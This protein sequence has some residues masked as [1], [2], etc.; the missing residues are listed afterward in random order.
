MTLPLSMRQRSSRPRE[1]P[2]HRT[3]L[4]S[5]GK[6]ASMGLLDNA[7]ELIGK[8]RSSISK[9]TRS[10]SLNN[11]LKELEK[12]KTALFARLGEALY[13]KRAISDSAKED[14]AALL[15]NIEDLDC[16]INEIA[17]TLES[18][19]RIEAAT[20]P[21]N[22]TC[23]KCGNL[24]QPDDAFC[25]SCGS[26]VERAGNPSFEETGVEVCPKCKAPVSP[27]QAFCVKCGSK[28]H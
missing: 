4:H 13:V 24:I 6:G 21:G 1:R 17:Y 23:P 18:L 2:T 12:Q 27:G 10:M 15:Q 11:E 7:E 19:N 26:P 9:T 16:R 14:N 3:A 5:V 22:R 8:T 20:N 25:R 28:I